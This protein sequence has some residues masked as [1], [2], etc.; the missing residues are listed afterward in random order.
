MG[1]V[2]FS[3]LGL[4]NFVE[5]HPDTLELLQQ[6]PLVGFVPFGLLFGQSS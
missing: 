3:S 5:G 1:L 6:Y 2:A 4:G